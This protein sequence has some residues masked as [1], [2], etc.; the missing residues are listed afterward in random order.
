L[1]RHHCNAKK[2]QERDG[3]V[4]S[5]LKSN[6]N[7][8]LIRWEYSPAVVRIE[9]CRLIAREDLPLWFGDFDAFQEYIIRAH[10]PKFVKCSRQ[11]TARDLIKL[12]NERVLKLIESF[13]RR[14]DPGGSL[15]RRV[16]CRCVPQPRWVGARWN[17]GGKTVASCCPALEWVRLQ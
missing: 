16:N 11:T 13:C 15:D 10:N 9:L 2:E 4:Q 12:Y 5:I 3:I 14:F 6:H 1:L 8:S 7:G 17:T